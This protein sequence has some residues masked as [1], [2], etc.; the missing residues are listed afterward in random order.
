MTG[1]GERGPVAATVRLADDALHEAGGHQPVDEPG[2]ARAG[3]E[4]PIGKVAHPEPVLVSGR[5]LDEDVV[6]REGHLLLDLELTLELANDAGV[7]AQEGAPGGQ[8]RL[9]AHRVLGIGHRLILAYS[10]GSN[11]SARRSAGMTATALL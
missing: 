1:V 9:A 8:A 7:G 10:C 6:V 3:E 4:E 5:E 11:H 2:G